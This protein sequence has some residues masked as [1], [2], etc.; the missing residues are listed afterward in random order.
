MWR[1]TLSKA[2]L[3][4]RWLAFGFDFGGI[5]ASF[6]D[7]TVPLLEI[8]KCL[9]CWDVDLRHILQRANR[10]AVAQVTQPSPVAQPAERRGVALLAARSLAARVVV[11]LRKYILW[12]GS[13][14]YRAS[15]ALLFDFLYL[16]S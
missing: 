13:P 15:P 6:F 4:S 1:M 8:L 11:V 9:L 3:F 5:S 7:D 12:I 10:P 16:V 2:R 14:A